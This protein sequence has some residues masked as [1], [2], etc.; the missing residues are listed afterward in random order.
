VNGLGAKA[1]FD[2]SVAMLDPRVITSRGWVIHDRTFPTLDLS[3]RDSARQELR[4]RVAC[5]DW[6]DSPPSVGLLAPDGN[7]LTAVPPQRPGSTI[8]NGSAHP[9]TGRPFVCMIGVREYHQHSSHT[10][11]VWSNYKTRDSYTLGNVVEQ[12]WRGWWRFWP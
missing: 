12:L 9:S 11:D 6:N 10:S 3:F 1:L 8:F 2:A 4:L 7:L 5:D